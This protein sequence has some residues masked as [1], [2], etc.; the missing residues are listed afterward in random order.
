MS[1]NL[2]VKTQVPL[3]IALHNLSE[4]YFDVL[5]FERLIAILACLKMAAVSPWPEQEAPLFTGL[6]KKLLYMTHNLPR[7]ITL[8][9]YNYIRTRYGGPYGKDMDRL[10][11]FLNELAVQDQLTSKPS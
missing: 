5:K 10:M 3:P 4:V 6:A 2:C 11:K 8:K 7:P 9:D 1:I